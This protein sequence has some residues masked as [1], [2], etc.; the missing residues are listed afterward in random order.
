MLLIVVSG[1]FL[2]AGYWLIRHKN[3]YWHRRAM[4]TATVFAA[5]FLVV[6]VTR[7]ALFGSKL[8]PGEGL[9]RVIYF[10][11]LVPHV[12]LA[13]AVA[14]LALVTIRRALAGQY[15]RH[16]QIARVTLPTWGFVAVSGWAVYWMLYRL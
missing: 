6:Y 14:P 2:A 5:L 1:I 8:F 7:L 9:L 3:V 4:L 12:I 11:I 10:A 15:G 16:R 13:I